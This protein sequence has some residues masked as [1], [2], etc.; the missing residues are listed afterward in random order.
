MKQLNLKVK[1]FTAEA[2]QH[3]QTI[4]IYCLNNQLNSNGIA[5]SSVIPYRA[6]EGIVQLNC[7]SSYDEIRTE[8]IVNTVFRQVNLFDTENGDFEQYTES[9]KQKLTNLLSK[10]NFDNKRQQYYK[11]I[12]S[13]MKLKVYPPY[14]MQEALIREALDFDKENTTDAEANVINLHNNLHLNSWVWKHVVNTSALNPLRKEAIYV[15]TELS[16]LGIKSIEEVQMMTNTTLKRIVLIGDESCNRIATRQEVANIT[17]IRNAIHYKQEIYETVQDKYLTCC[18]A[19]MY[20]SNV[21]NNIRYIYDILNDPTCN[22]SY[23]LRFSDLRKLSELTAYNISI[24]LV[25]EKWSDFLLANR[26]I[27]ANILTAIGL[28]AKRLF[29]YWQTSKEP[30]VYPEDFDELQVYYESQNVDIDVL[31]TILSIDA[32]VCD[33]KKMLQTI[34]KYGVKHTSDQLPYDIATQMLKRKQTSLSDKQFAIIERRY[35]SIMKTLEMSKTIDANECLRLANELN[36]R[37]KDSMNNTVE[38]IVNSTLRYGICSEKQLDVL[39]NAYVTLA[40]NNDTQAANNGPVITDNGLMF[41]LPNNAANNTVSKQ[42]VTEKNNDLLA[43]TTKHNMAED[44]YKNAFG[45]TS[46]TSGSTDSI[47]TD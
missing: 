29:P 24:K 17:N 3:L 43:Q 6:M 41:N 34:K 25:E 46:S 31:S 4:F 36:S 27:T 14:S 12:K 32:E 28:N 35:N 11:A 30:V 44:A 10:R 21:S 7:A 33:V 22:I 42:N 47:W 39:R 16:T 18:L 26:D 8:Q 40:S 1:D 37:F 2:K 45:D 5:I 20:T 9:E 15:A 38:N 13:L 19:A 23:E